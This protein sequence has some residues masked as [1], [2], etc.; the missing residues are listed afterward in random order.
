MAKKIKHKS[1]SPVAHT[2]NNEVAG[3]D[4][5]SKEIFVAVS[6][7]KTPDCVRCFSTF[8]NDIKACLAWLKELN[9]QSVAMESTGIYWIPVYDIL[10]QGGIEVCLVNARHVKNVPGRK[11]DVQ[12]CMW[13]Q[14]LHSVGL[15]RGSFRPSGDVVALRSLYRHRETLIKQSAISTQHMQKSLT[16]MNVYIH[17]VISDITGKTGLNIIEAILNGQTKPEEL[18][19]LKDIRI[20]SSDKILVESLTGNYKPEHLFTLK[21]ALKIY[22]HLRDLIM[23][24]DKEIEKLLQ[25]FNSQNPTPLPKKKRARSRNNPSFD[26]GSQVYRILGVDLT[27]IDGISELTAH[28]IFTEIGFDIAKFKSV[29][30]FASWLGLAPNNKVSGGKVLATKTGK[31]SNPIAKAL[32]LSAQTLWNSKS[33]L[34]N[35]YRK[36][37][38]KLGPSKANTATAHKLSRIVYAMLRY[39]TEYN[40]TLFEEQEQKLLHKRKKNLIKQA[41]SLGLTF[42]MP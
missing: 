6:Q 3:I 40:P 4:I 37:R 23:E 38:A 15:L 19:K 18:V 42:A 25:G 7:D 26:L 28:T 39:K 32:R 30:H 24:T 12:D 31:S 22:Y 33:Y 14:Y 34:G 2:I 10:E 27:Q 16:Q 8:T 35:F 9:I 5:G 29:N 41:K 11:T 17:N 21:Q 13:I 20:K 36:M 1:H